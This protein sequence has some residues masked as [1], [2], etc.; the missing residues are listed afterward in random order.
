MKKKNFNALLIGF[1]VGVLVYG[2][3]NNNLG[4]W[5]LIPIVSIC[6]IVKADKG[7]KE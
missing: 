6:L 3:A 5:L 4:L 2:I 1:M 7:E